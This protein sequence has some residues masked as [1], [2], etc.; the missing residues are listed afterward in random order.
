LDYYF[1]DTTCYCTFSSLLP[2]VTTHCLACQNMHA[3][4][5]WTLNFPRLQVPLICCLTDNLLLISSTTY[6]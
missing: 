5:V 6:I 3:F 4:F 2:L 1:H